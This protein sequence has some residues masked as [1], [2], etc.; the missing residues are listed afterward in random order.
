MFTRITN[1]CLTLL[2]SRNATT[3]YCVLLWMEEN[4]QQLVK[5]NEFIVSLSENSH[6]F[7]AFNTGA[8]HSIRLRLKCLTRVITDSN[9]QQV[10]ANISAFL[11]TDSIS[12]HA[13]NLC[14]HFLSHE[15][16]EA[17]PG[18]AKE[19]LSDFL[20]AGTFA[21]DRSILL[22]LLTFTH[23]EEV[24]VDD[25]FSRL[26]GLWKELNELELTTL[27]TL[28]GHHAHKSSKYWTYMADICDFIASNAKISQKV[29]SSAT[30]TIRCGLLAA[31][32]KCFQFQPVEYKDLLI[33]T[34]SSC[35]GSSDGGSSGGGG[36]GGSS[37]ILQ[38]QVRC[39]HQKLRQ[40]QVI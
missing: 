31:L 38:E 23:Y 20:T 11:K 22:S 18:V 34:L 5:S 35:G 29:Q 16:L 13:S 8:V 27:L 24:K 15:L 40:L 10:T 26:I 9:V 3:N 14:I 19:A 17:Y 25:L 28:C 1:T 32:V 36:S 33:Q 39:C 6:L 12:H 2:R 7:S 21:T 4:L 37:V 30:T